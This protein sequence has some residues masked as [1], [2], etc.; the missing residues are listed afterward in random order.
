MSAL[1]EIGMDGQEP[2]KALENATPLTTR[3]GTVILGRMD[4]F[5]VLLRLIGMELYKIRRSLM[6]KALGV[7]AVAL[8]L[9]VALTVGVEVAINQ[10]TPARQFV[11]SCST[12]TGNPGQADCSAGTMQR[13]KQ[14]LLAILSEPLR[15]PT[16][17]E[18][19][20]TQGE[21][22]PAIILLIV[23]IGSSAGGELSIGTVRLMFTRG[24]WRGQF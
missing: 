6:S 3:I 12:Q 2:K 11:P 24:P 8:S 19:A 10:N 22:N 7:V 4:F 23:L 17:F 21:L 9:L 20:A 16:S 14:V 1:P 5:S 15:L 18:M 13:N